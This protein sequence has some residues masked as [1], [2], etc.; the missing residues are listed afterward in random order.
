MDPDHEDD[1]DEGEELIGD[2]MMADYKPMPELDRYE[3]DDLDTADYEEM[4][5]SSRA[6]A[7]ALMRARDNEA[8]QRAGRRPAM[9]EASDDEEEA[10]PRHRRRVA[11]DDV[12]QAEAADV[13]VVD[14]DEGPA[15]DIKSMQG[16]SFK[17]Y[18]QLEPFRREVR[19]LF[20]RFLLTY[21]EEGGPRIYP[22][23]IQEMCL[24]N[25]QSFTI[26]YIHL[27][28]A[29][30][31]LGMYLPDTPETMLEL[32]DDEATAYVAET[33]SNYHRVHSRIHVRLDN[34]SIVDKI[35]DL[36][37]SHLNLLVKIDGVVTRRTGAFP[38]L[39]LVKFNC[40]KCGT[41]VGPITVSSTNALHTPGRCPECQSKGPFTVNSEQTIYQNYQKATVQENPGDMQPGRV[42]RHKEVILLDDL[43]DAVTPGEAVQIT[44]TYKH[45]LDMSLNSLNGFP[46][47]NTVILANN[48]SKKSSQ[49]TARAPA[50]VEAEIIKLSKRPDIAQVL[51]NSF[52]PSI[53]GHENIKIAMLLSL[54][55]GVAKQFENKHRIRGDIN[56]LL[57]GDPGTAKSQF[58][59][60]VQK[61][62]K[63][64]IYTT[65]K[66]A[67]AVGLTASVRNDPV[68][69]EWTLEGGALVLADTG[70]CLI[71]EF[72]KMNDQDRTS[73]HEAMEQ[74]SI[75]ISKAGIIATLK[76]RCAVIAAA[77]PKAGRFDSSLTFTENVDLT[78]PILS[79][80]D[81]LLVVR[82]IVDQDNDRRLARFV[83]GSH[84]ASSPAGRADESAAAGAAEAMPEADAAPA[85]EESA[86]QPGTRTKDTISQE[87][88][89][90]YIAYA[91]EHCQPQLTNVDE[92]KLSRLYADLRKQS[93]NT[94]GI[95]IAVRHME[96]ILR[97]AE[98]HAKMH[99]RSFVSDDDVNMAIRVMLES[100]LSTQ[101]FSVMK[102]LRQHFK[103]YMTYKWDTF[104]LLL[105]ALQGL[106]KEAREYRMARASLHPGDED[107]VLNEPIEIPIDEF[108]TK[109]ADL[110]ISNL[111]P[112]FNSTVFSEAHFTYDR[113]RRPPVIIFRDPL[114]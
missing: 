90:D 52:A 104:E 81:I 79:R 69:R 92:D 51:Y 95:P 14:R 89:R 73:I 99:L 24:N 17:E 32:F 45:Q 71:D 9:L 60:C 62:S 12:D 2:S 13:A 91:R 35:R 7:E 100:F 53:H 22:P 113:M 41:I 110:Q 83:V 94:G 64:A 57:L 85:D 28:R 25:R 112:F 46:V 20:R 3:E 72:D 23:K 103:K 105:H 66:G 10:R 67:S 84:M 114:D 59:K 107:A 68:T 93:M 82:D 106:V 26:D 34:L 19:R 31:S 86:A 16:S 38:Q 5:P 54:F 15:V 108:Q 101:K 44:G 47:F 96:S 70:V 29:E 76:A 49:A 6:K 80:F 78:G 4:S 102:S 1:G 40:A 48:I 75:S 39:K 56:V 111:E 33:F 58:L 74:Q 43:M 8:A 30:H 97:M 42:P 50:E 87:M 27:C 37:Q 77:N 88:L 98:A 21:S 65:G 11:D 109:A 36:R 61:V 55:G 18:L 63:R